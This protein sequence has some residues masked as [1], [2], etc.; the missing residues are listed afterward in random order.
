VGGLVDTLR[1]H[2]RI[3]FD[4]S[5]FVYHI[6]R[7]T[8]YAGLARE[9]FELLR[10]ESCQG[11]TSVI[12]LIEVMIKPL[13]LQRP[14]AATAYE[15]VITSLPNL[16]VV[17]L[18]HLT[19]RR[20]TELRARHNLRTPDALQI[21]ACLRHGAT[22]FLTNDRRLRRVPDLEIVVLESHVLPG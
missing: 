11:I 2:R 4:T 15:A 8:R 7:S 1:A 3:G 6:E 9:A 18:D 13:R 17:G 5:I 12:T 19:A 20:A 14:D 21:G 10:S 22:A 16:D